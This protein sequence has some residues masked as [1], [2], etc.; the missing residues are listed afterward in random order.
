MDAIANTKSAAP[1]PSC[2]VGN[3]RQPN[4]CKKYHT[5]KQLYPN[6][7]NDK[8][9]GEWRLET[10]EHM[11]IRLDTNRYI[12]SLPRW[13]PRPRVRVAQ[14]RQPLSY[15]GGREGGPAGRTERCLWQVVPKRLRK[16]TLANLELAPPS[17][18]RT[19]VTSMVDTASGPGIAGHFPIRHRDPKPST[20]QN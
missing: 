6:G 18:P 14:A 12:V 16:D 11:N 15:T 9:I 4:G 10:C 13:E 1:K 8:E 7:S 2:H 5:Q 3:K 20:N 19:S 17:D